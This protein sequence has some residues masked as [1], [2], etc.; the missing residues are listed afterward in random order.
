MDQLNFGCQN[1]RKL[2]FKRQL[3]KEQL[4][5]YAVNYIWIRWYLT[6]RDK[7]SL[8]KLNLSAFWP[9]QPR[10]KFFYS[11]IFDSKDI[12]HL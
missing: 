12:I 4:C 5:T 2:A 7:T 1:K 6:L 8:L 9:L 11:I 10:L 3:A